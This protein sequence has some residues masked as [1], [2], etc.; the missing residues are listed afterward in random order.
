MTV[1]P[2]ATMDALCALRPASFTAARQAH[3]AVRVFPGNLRDYAPC[4]R[5]AVC[6]SIAPPRSAESCRATCSESC[7]IFRVLLRVLSNAVLNAR[8]QMLDDGFIGL[9]YR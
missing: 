9:I 7:R 2:M 4:C 8:Y 1:S 5:P 3:R 6:D